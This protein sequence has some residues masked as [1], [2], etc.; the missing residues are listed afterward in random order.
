MKRLRVPASILCL[1]ASLNACMHQ[2]SHSHLL[3][4]GIAVSL[5]LPLRW[6]KPTWFKWSLVLPA[7]AFSLLLVDAYLLRHRYAV[8]SRSWSIMDADEIEDR[9]ESPSGRT[10]VYVVGNH[11]LD[12]SYRVYVSHGHLFPSV[13]WLETE[14]SDPV[15][16]RDI[17]ARW[18]GP[19]FVAGEGE[20]SLSVAYD[21]RDDRF[22]SYRDWAL[23]GLS[24]PRTIED[25]TKELHIIE[26]TG[27]NNEDAN[28]N[29]S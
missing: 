2:F 29:G 20:D 1:L 28:G 19:F 27:A 26:K 22:Y 10:T 4:I 7:V 8:E 9:L 6:L 14:S 5:L 12:S 16:P 25:F 3:P 17:I 11:W 24:A 18:R 13:G 15:Y 21:E 23:G